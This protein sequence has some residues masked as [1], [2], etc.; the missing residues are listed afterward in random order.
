MASIKNFEKNIKRIEEIVKIL[1]DGSI[2]LDKSLSVYA[3]AAQLIKDCSSVLDN[4][5]KKVKIL[6]CAGEEPVINEFEECNMEDKIEG[7]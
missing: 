5:E 1:E 4:A 3:E 7:D 6:S 2:P